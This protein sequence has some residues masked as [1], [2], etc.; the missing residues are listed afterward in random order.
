MSNLYLGF[1]KA[2]A[3]SS[4][5]SLIKQPSSKSNEITLPASCKLVSQT[6]LQTSLINVLSLRLREGYTVKD[7]EIDKSD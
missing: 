6:V 4:S 1:H 7:V 5:Q 2:I 3:D